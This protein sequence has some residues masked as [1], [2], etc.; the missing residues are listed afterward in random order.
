MRLTTANDDV[1]RDP[2]SYELWGT[3]DPIQSVEH[4]NGLGGENWT[5]ISSG[6]LSLPWRRTVRSTFVPINAG[7]AYN[8]YKL[9]FPTVRN[10]AAPTRCKLPMCSFTPGWFQSRQ[11]SR[12]WRWAWRSVGVSRPSRLISICERIQ[13]AY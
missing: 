1:G 2:A 6:A 11:R 5:L 9:I 10:A 7:A 4:S 12:W 3:N 13:N 8:S